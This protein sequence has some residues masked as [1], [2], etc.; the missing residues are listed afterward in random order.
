[1]FET[2]PRLRNEISYLTMDPELNQKVLL[3]VG[4]GS[5]MQGMGTADETAQGHLV[6]GVLMN[7]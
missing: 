5:V 3:Q 1:M 4:Q 6:V 2:I 7:P